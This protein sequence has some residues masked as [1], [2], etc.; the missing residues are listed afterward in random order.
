MS[1]TSASVKRL[2][3][4]VD[5]LLAKTTKRRSEE[6]SP[7][8]TAK[9]NS[10]SSKALRLD[11]DVTSPAHRSDDT[12]LTVRVFTP[13]HSHAST[14]PVS[15]HQNA[16]SPA[17]I[18]HHDATSPA[19]I[20]QHDASPPPSLRHDATSSS[21][22]DRG[23]PHSSLQSPYT[24]G[25][26]DDDEDGE[27]DIDDDADVDEDVKQQTHGKENSFQ[28]YQLNVSS[29]MDKDRFG[30]ME[31]QFGHHG[32]PLGWGQ[33]LTMPWMAMSAFPKPGKFADI[34]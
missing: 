22:S 17:S 24:D 16:S 13:P 18:S 12:S 19:V 32:V 20:R 7:Q 5:S 33:H 15:R 34:T 11:N 3:F 30:R 28:T 26:G 31:G 23:S 29:L 25:G 14:S 1:E 9:N 21:H 6:V 4:S 10:D 8:Q 2:P 27:I